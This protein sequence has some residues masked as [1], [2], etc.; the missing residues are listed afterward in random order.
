MV[1]W[2]ENAMP[3]RHDERLWVLESGSAAYA[4]GAD[5]G[6]LLLHV[7]WGA[8]LSHLA[9]YRLPA[10]AAAFPTDH[11]FQLTNMEC[12]TGEASASDQ[13]NIDGMAAD[14]SIRGL[15]LRFVG[16]KVAG[17]MVEI[18]LR[19]DALSLRVVLRYA[20]LET[21]GL[22]SRTVSII[23]DG[24]QPFK[25][26]RAFSGTFNLPDCGPFA[27][28]NLDGRWGDE[29]RIQRDPMPYGTVQRESRRIITSHGGVPFFAIDRTEP[30]LAAS[31]ESGAVWFGTLEWSGNWRLIA[32]RTRDDRTVVHLG[33]NDHDFAWDLMPGETF[34]TPR[35]VFGYTEDGF[36]AMS[37][38]FH[39]LIRDDLAPR[40][41]WLPPVVYNSWYATTFH[42]DEAGQT[43]LAEKAA[44]MG[45]EMFVMDDGWFHGRVDD[46]AGLGDWWPDAAKFPNGLGPL[47]RA[48]KDRGM[49][50]GLWIEPEMVNPNS[51]LYAAHP[52]WV[53]HFPGRERTELRNQLL[54]NMGRVDVQDYLI[55]IFDRLLR[56]ND[57]DFVKWDMNRSA[58]EPGWPSHDRDQREI[59]VRY[60]HGLNRVWQTLRD[61]HP[62]VIW[63]N[64]ASGGGRVDL[65]MMG[66]TEQSWASDNTFA[67]ARRLI[68]EG[69]SQIFPA[70]TMAAWVTDSGDYSLDLKFHVSMAGAMGVGGNLLTWS[71]ADC[72]RAATHV[73]TYKT[74]RPLIAK[75]DL[76]RIR[77]AHDHAVSALAYVAKDKSEAALFAFRMHEPRLGRDPGMRHGDWG[78][79]EGRPIPLPGLD[80]DA[81]YT[82][83]APHP[84]LSGRALAKIGLRLKLDDFDSMVLHVKRAD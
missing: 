22:F 43:A 4:F 6:G 71:E 68:Q 61:R 69:Y 49:G 76:Y 77:S 29:F 44:A 46:K 10:I 3:I 80:P 83:D 20:V 57:I 50:F 65:A 28:T 59:W 35:L 18:T 25:I 39:D 38:S 32:E 31:E 67:P 23:N 15:V 30:G 72:A 11:P 84:A 54:L 19:D 12:V 62:R 27:L 64:C 33:L 58:S 81:I 56:E 34:E 42:V 51:Q 26:T 78:L 9:D 82:T 48:V 47:I 40:K 37:R 1:V 73:A 41:D 55:D 24:S 52:D 14:G 70:G 2:E 13:R 53:V 36:G 16:A 8:A 5:A 63:E 79:G 75:G 66:L 60:V 17:E 7:H 21:P 45:V 74:L